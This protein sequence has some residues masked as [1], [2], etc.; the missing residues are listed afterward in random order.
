MWLQLVL[1]NLKERVWSTRGYQSV[2]LEHKNYPISFQK[3]SSILVRKNHSNSIILNHWFTYSC[4]YNYDLRL[5]FLHLQVPFY[6]Y[7]NNLLMFLRIHLY[8]WFCV[9]IDNADPL[10]LLY[11]F[12]LPLPADNHL[13]THYCYNYYTFHCG[14]LNVLGV[15]ILVSTLS[16]NYVNKYTKCR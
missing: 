1:I 6:S 16:N 8:G 2:I 9:F 12:W 10:W 3:L 11:I 13:F 14:L 7:W 4:C 15:D 5:W